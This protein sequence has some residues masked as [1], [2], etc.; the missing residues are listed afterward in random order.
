MALLRAWPLSSP[1]APSPAWLPARPLPWPPPCGPLRVGRQS[2]GQAMRHVGRTDE[3]TFAIGCADWASVLCSVHASC[4]KHTHHSV[5]EAPCGSRGT[6]QSRLVS[7]SWRRQ[8]SLQPHLGP[9]EGRERLGCC[10]QDV[11]LTRHLLAGP[12]DAHDG[13]ALAERALR[14]R[15]CG[16]VG[17]R[18]VVV[19]RILN[20]RS[21]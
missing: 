13:N 19:D 3:R 6:A 1:W 11:L 14:Q 15:H 18:L 20:L 10:R 12:H 2:D 4:A 17:D 9:L 8:S 7:A 16:A 5:P 21:V